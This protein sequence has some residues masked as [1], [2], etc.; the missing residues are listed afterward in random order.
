MPMQPSPIAETVKPCLPSRFCSMCFL[1]VTLSGAS[2]GFPEHELHTGR[3]L[4]CSE[5][6]SSGVGEPQR[7]PVGERA[8]ASLAR[9]Q[10]QG[11]AEGDVARRNGRGFVGRPVLSGL[12]L[13]ASSPCSVHYSRR[14]AAD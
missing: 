12:L 6:P 14:T 11:V 9:R 8:E 5:N 3:L 1:L 13:T 10:A 2:S 4:G 7:H